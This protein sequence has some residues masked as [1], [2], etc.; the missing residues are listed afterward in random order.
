MIWKK[1]LLTL[2]VLSS[3]VWAAEKKSHAQ[4]TFSESEV[5]ALK[6]EWLAEQKTQWLQQAEQ[7]EKQREAFLI[8]DNLLKT[9]ISSKQFSAETQRLVNALIRSL[10]TYPLKRDIDW[11][12][13][14][15]KIESKQVTADDIRA[16]S[17]LYPN[18]P[19]QKQF[20][21]LPFAQLYEQQKWLTY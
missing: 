12:V 11:A 17:A 16:F 1:T 3:S 9:A 13:L 20:E 7:R 6:A 10:D 18:S 5:T 2:L 15:A 4:K 21:Q 19:Y 14:K 8:A